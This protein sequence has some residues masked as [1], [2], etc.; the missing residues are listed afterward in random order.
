[1]G[2]QVHGQKRA[3][4]VALHKAPALFGPACRELRGRNIKPA[5]Q[6]LRGP[7]HGSG[8]SERFDGGAQ[9]AAPQEVELPRSRAPR[10]PGRA[11]AAAGP[12]RHG[13]AARS[14]SKQVPP[15][16]I[17]AIKNAVIRGLCFNNVVKYKAACQLGEFARPS[18]RRALAR[19]A[20]AA[21]AGRIEDLVAGAPTVGAVARS[22]RRPTISRTAVPET[23]ECDLS[24]RAWESQERALKTTASCAFRVNLLAA[25][26]G[27]LELTGRALGDGR[28]RQSLPIAPHHWGGAA[29]AFVEPETVQTAFFVMVGHSCG[30]LAAV[31]YANAKAALI[32]D[33]LRG[34]CKGLRQWLGV[35]F[36]EEKARCCAG[37]VA[38]GFGCDLLSEQPLIAFAEREE[39]SWRAVGDALAIGILAPAFAAKLKGRLGRV[40]ARVWG[41]VGGA[42]LRALS[43]RQ[44]GGGRVVNPASAGPLRLRRSFGA[45]AGL[46]A[47]P[48]FTWVQSQ[49][50]WFSNRDDL[51]SLAVLSWQ[52]RAEASVAKR[53]GRVPTDANPGDGASRGDFGGLVQ[54][55]AQR[56][57]MARA[58]P[59]GAP[60]MG[61]GKRRGG[62]MGESSGW[63]SVTW[64]SDGRTF[65]IEQDGVG[66]TDA[67][68]DS[69]I[70]TVHRELTSWSE[71]RGFSCSSL[72][73]SRNELTDS[74]V[75]K[76]MRFLIQTRISVQMLKL[77]KNSFGDAGMQSIGEFISSQAAEPVQEIHLSHNQITWRGALAVF[78]AVKDCGLYP[79]NRGKDGTP[80]WLRMENNLIDW[81]NVISKLD[82]WKMHMSIGDNRDS[83]KSDVRRGKGGC[84]GGG[85]GDEAAECPLVAMHYSYHHQTVRDKGHG[86]GDGYEGWDEDEYGD[87]DAGEGYDHGHR[88]DRRRDRDRGERDRDRDRERDR[89][90]RDRHERD[91]HERDRLERDRV[92]RDRH[93]RDRDRGGAAA[94]PRAEGSRSHGSGGYT[95]CSACGYWDWNNRFWKQKGYCRCGSWAAPQQHFANRPPAPTSVDKAPSLAAAERLKTASFEQ[96]QVGKK[97]ARCC[98]E[99]ATAKHRVQEA[100]ARLDAPWR[101][102]S[103]PRWSTRCRPR[104]WWARTSTH[105]LP[106]RLAFNLDPSLFADMDDADEDYMTAVEALQSAR[107]LWLEEQEKD[108]NTLAERAELRESARLE[109]EAKFTQAQEEVTRIQSGKAAR[110]SRMQHDL[111]AKAK[112]RQAAKKRR[113]AEGAVV[114]GGA[115]AAHAGSAAA[116]AP[117]LCAAESPAPP[118]PVTSEADGADADADMGSKGVDGPAAEA[119]MPEPSLE[120]KAQHLAHTE[121]VREKAAKGHAEQLAARASAK[122][123]LASEPLTQEVKARGPPEARLDGFATLTMHLEQGNLVD[124]AAHSFPG[125]GMSGANRRRFQSLAV[126]LASLADPWVALAELNATPEELMRT[127]FPQKVP[128]ELPPPLTRRP[129]QQS[130][131]ESKA[132]KRR[133]T[134]LAR[135]RDA[136]AAHLQADFAAMQSESDAAL[137]AARAEAEAREAAVLDDCGPSVESFGGG[138]L[139]GSA[140]AEHQG[141]SGAGQAQSI[142]YDARF[143]VLRADAGLGVRAEDG[144]RAAAAWEDCGPGDDFL[145]VGMGVPGLARAPSLPRPAEAEEVLLEPSEVPDGERSQH[146]SRAAGNDFRWPPLKPSPGRTHLRHRASGHWAVAP[147][148]LRQIARIRRQSTVGRGQQDRCL[149]VLLR[150]AANITMHTAGHFPRAAEP[151]VPPAWDPMVNGAQEIHAEELGVMAAGAERFAIDAQAR[152]A[153]QHRREFA[154]RA[155]KMRKEL[156]VGGVPVT[157]P[158]HAMS[159][160]AARWGGRRRAPSDSWSDL[161]AALQ[162]AKRRVRESPLEP[163][164]RSSI[165]LAAWVQGSK[166]ARGV[167]GPGSGDLER[168]PPEG[169]E[170]LRPLLARCEVQLFLAPRYLRNSHHGYS[171]QVE[172]T[173]SV[174]AVSAHGVPLGKLD[175]HPLLQQAHAMRPR[176]GLWS[177]IGDTAIRCE[178]SA[179]SSEEELPRMAKVLKDGMDAAQGLICS[180]RTVLAA[181]SSE[182]AANLSDSLVAMGIPHS[183]SNKAVDLGI[184]AAFWARPMA[185]GVDEWRLA[186]AEDDSIRARADF[187]GALQDAEEDLRH[188]LWRSAASHLHGGDLVG[189]AGFLHI[190]RELKMLER[191]T[192]AHGI[193]QCPANAGEDLESTA[194]LSPR[195]L[196]GHEASSAMWLRWAPAPRATTPV[197]CDQR[198]EQAAAPLGAD[199]A[200]GSTRRDGGFA[201]VYGDGSRGKLSDDPRRR[202]CATSIA[203]MGPDEDGLWTDLRWFC[204][205]PV[206]GRRQTAPLAEI[207]GFALALES[208]CGNI[209]YVTYHKPLWRCWERKMS[210]ALLGGANEDLWQRARQ[211]WRDRPPG[212]IER[213]AGFQAKVAY[214][215]HAAGAA[216]EEGAD[217]AVAAGAAE[218]GADAA[219]GAYLLHAS[220]A[221]AE[222]GAGAAEE[223]AVADPDL[224]D[225]AAHPEAGLAQPA[226]P[227]PILGPA[228]RDG[229]GGRDRSRAPARELDAGPHPDAGPSAPPPADGAEPGAGDEA[230]SPAQRLGEAAAGALMVAVAAIG[231]AQAVM[232]EDVGTPPAPS[233]VQGPP[234]GSLAAVPPASAPAL[235]PA[236]RVA[237]SGADS[238]NSRADGGDLPGAA[239]ADASPAPRIGGAAGGAPGAAG[240]PPAGAEDRIMCWKSGQ[241]ADARRP[242]A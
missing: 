7:V 24:R 42:F 215:L 40:A 201:A 14:G 58:W 102:I 154:A 65:K 30:L 112:L 18:Q 88:G 161:A 100:Q 76:V 175:L 73:L 140:G 124:A 50:R 1:M 151:E 188:Q 194:A 9:G 27:S 207:L 12:R 160:K 59:Q 104:L 77:F 241:A 39:D 226:V 17:F 119:S 138:E 199:S 211:A 135:R 132:S 108:Y 15:G 43:E 225:G 168:P 169:C 142:H 237:E 48:S 236:L 57:E 147:A 56:A 16:E 8:D 41:C 92:E 46:E 3:N 238:A 67:N 105:A 214:M 234:A 62:E 158:S 163:L 111:Q 144:A 61:K 21:D 223:G 195:A 64:A 176:A 182:L 242:G 230:T 200:L 120:R 82:E 33:S 208:V 240:R 221:G 68:I 131:P 109:E 178:G 181:P 145:G 143:G 184:D 228:A 174:V 90:D 32:A 83:W 193:W 171:M 203:A 123:A 231:A 37:P 45:A 197:C 110:L 125:C 170:E 129:S 86:R 81:N 121:S 190:G 219:T 172:A 139:G 227:G 159:Q 128:G 116:A 222:D 224:P 91:R 11:P 217:A 52:L 51:R 239:N 36:A 187:G 117:S 180:S 63:A 103:R 186:G 55:G 148:M 157:V 205:A 153:G 99:L 202:R 233:L 35:D 167:D 136:L 22:G 126:F 173:R 179:K 13:R 20:S 49:R 114:G 71:G 75:K 79:C 44:R 165:D 177:I 113:S 85:K 115:E 19:V 54:A 232:P 31:Y 229:Q 97:V 34:R 53:V 137:L 162:G 107:R 29:V 2:I 196:A 156:A 235:P 74:S 149:E 118:T 220:G 87:W 4:F 96:E 78:G 189:G 192:L 155:R 204:V 66:I 69:W 47:R 213:D 183:A 70:S 141:T 206:P 95:M 6:V 84:K 130:D 10:I 191:E 25:R 38:L 80:L 127:G 152:A 5:A 133:A 218:E 101:S 98:W 28:T 164:G 122:A 212:A 185:E 94:A 26:L 134:A 60:A 198:A 23:S 210:S 209:R 106:E 89:H 93:E 146:R 72:S 166:R 216:A 150:G